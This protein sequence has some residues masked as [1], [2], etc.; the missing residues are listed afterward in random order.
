MRRQ[1]LSLLTSAALCLSLLPGAALAY[2]YPSQPIT[3]LTIGKTKIAENT[4]YTV[5]DGTI[6]SGGTSDNYNIYYHNN[7]LTLK[8][9]KLTSAVYVP[10]G[11]T[12]ELQGENISGSAA[13]KV[14]IGIQAISSG[15]ITITGTGSYEVYTNYEGIATVYA[16]GADGKSQSNIIISGGKLDLHGAPISTRYG[17]LTITG[18]AQVTAGSISTGGDPNYDEAQR[19]RDLI[20][21]GNA[22]VTAECISNLQKIIIRGNAAVSVENKS[23]I[24]ISG[25]RGIEISGNAEVSASGNGG[26]LNSFNGSISIGGK[27]VAATNTEPLTSNGGTAAVSTG[28]AVT[29]TGSI[30]VTG[31]LTVSSKYA[32]M[33]TTG[34]GNIVVDGGTVEME[35]S[36][37]GL[38]TRMGGASSGGDISI[39][40][41]ATVSIAG[42]AMGT[43]PMGASTLTI[44]SSTVEIG[45]TSW[46]LYW[47]GPIV[48]KNGTVICTTND[49]AIGTNVAISYQY[50]NGYV[51]LAG[52]TADSSESIEQ[53]EQTSHLQNPYVKIEP[54]KVISVGG[55]AL[56]KTALSLTPGGTAELDATVTPDNATDKS[57]TWTSGDTSVATVDANGTIIAVA[58]GTATITATA[59]DSSGK[60]ASCTVTV[61]PAVTPIVPGDT[62]RYIVEHYRES[63]SGYVLAETEYPAGK[64]GETVTA[65]PKDYDGYLY[66][67]T[68]S[69]PSGTLKAIQSEAD[70]LTLKLY[71]DEAPVISWPGESDAPTY[72][73]T[74]P[75]EVEGGTVT[76]RPVWAEKGETVTITV[77]PDEGY[78][79]GELTVTGKDGEELRLA[80]KSENKFTFKMPASRVT[81]EASFV[82]IEDEPGEVVDIELPFLDVSEGAWYYD[83]VGYVYESGLMTGTG[84]ETFAP[85]QPTSRAM[86]A[87]ILYR[88]AG[89]P[90]VNTSV[91]FTDVGEGQW[92]TQAVR[93]AS[94]AGVV[95]GYGDGTFGPDAPITR[96]QLAV[97]LYRFAAFRGYDV[98]AGG[99]AVREFADYADISHWALEA[100]AW[101][102]DTG[103]LGGREGNVLDPAGTATRAEVAAVLQR[104]QENLK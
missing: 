27:T 36:P 58:P 41:G 21:E 93:W 34:T 94:S 25:N 56:D 68:V 67:K 86:I 18:D 35:N 42:A 7:T 6:A 71:Y 92:F 52:Q 51:F 39:T 82:E 96:E 100:M 8:D 12:V 50:S 30:T 81:V 61:I 101:A 11:T 44:D 26:A 10:G 80:E 3:D 77:T 79:L 14:S 53:S 48:L 102:V 64:I 15:S 9:A 66:N 37:F 75:D 47:P 40:D 69:T 16:D 60:S 23:G 49:K 5:E 83:A 63:R 43:Y 103:L 1:F 31:H 78:T 45:A 98:S 91:T 54:V 76:V 84:A 4:Y 13:K 87:A 89:S 95:I 65:Q 32:G 17:S 33:W 22:Q 38:L 104:F 29:S 55:I 85:E 90:M 62:V 28:Q 24:A 59:N 46:G 74:T 88:Q 57:V 2:D 73:V 72:R 97:M 19:A 99:M 70:L 20:I